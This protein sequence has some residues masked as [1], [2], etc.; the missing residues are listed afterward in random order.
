MRPS[1]HGQP[2]HPVDP[3]SKR[4]RAPSPEV[5]G[6]LVGAV[7]GELDHLRSDLAEELVLIRLLVD[8][9]HTEAA[10]RLLDEQSERLRH[11]QDHVEAAIASAVVERTAEEILADA[12]EM[13]EGAAFDPQVAVDSR[14]Q[15]GDSAA[16]TAVREEAPGPRLRPL[17]AA[18]CLLL[19]VA[20]F[21]SGGPLPALYELV[22]GRS[23]GPSDARR[24]GERT[25][26][27]DTDTAGDA[28]TTR[29]AEA[30]PPADGV[31]DGATEAPEILLLLGR[32]ARFAEGTSSAPVA[33]LL[34]VDRFVAR[35]VTEVAPLLAPLPPLPPEE[36]APRAEPAQ[37]DAARQPQPDTQPAP[38][39]GEP[40]N[41]Q[42]AE[43]PP[44]G[45]PLVAN[46]ADPA[47]QGAEGETLEER[48]RKHREQHESAPQPAATSSEVPHGLGQRP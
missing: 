35:L 25:G 3:G 7:G 16:Q 31:L 2:P 34:D 13:P 8:A 19:L 38:A 42:P 30:Q 20:V 11:F 21:L 39:V 40:A 46:P 10:R 9:G 28:T 12:A 32:L 5:T 18:A 37:P 47:D 27:G 33:A 15:S 23:S 26:G 22:S 17:V 44:P 29:P 41:Q 14:R 43:Q 48:W 45:A 36:T 4:R 6:R 1:E 24:E